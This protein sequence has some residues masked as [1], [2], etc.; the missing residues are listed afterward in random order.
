MVCLDAWEVCKNVANC[1]DCE[2]ICTSFAGVC[3]A[4]QY[5]QS[6]QECSLYRTAVKP[7]YGRKKRSPGCYGN[8][9]PSLN[10]NSPD[11]TYYIVSNSSS[12]TGGATAPP[13]VTYA[14]ATQPPPIV[15][16]PPPP[17]TQPPPP[18]QTT[19]APLPVTDPPPPPTTMGPGPVVSDSTPALPAQ[20][21]AS[22]GRNGKYKIY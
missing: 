8:A 2:A 16:E 12:C 22:L 4:I 3:Q 10:R 7:G 14:P 5:Q 21:T 13:V 6:T 9:P 18:P 17:V 1:Q 20:G 19:Q 11:F 15:T